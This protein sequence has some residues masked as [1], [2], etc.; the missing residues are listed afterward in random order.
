V[1]VKCAINVQ[2]EIINPE[3]ATAASGRAGAAAGPAG[4]SVAVGQAWTPGP[5]PDWCNLG[6]MLRVVLGINL[7]FLSI[8]GARAVN[9]RAWASEF[10]SL[11]VTVE[12]VLIA[13]LLIGCGLRRLG[14]HARFPGNGTLLIGLTVALP[15]V[16]T[17]LLQHTMHP[18]VSLSAFELLRNALFAALLAAFVIYW[19]RLR[20]RA[21]SPALVEARLQALQ[22]RIRPHFLF[23][24]LNAVLGMMRADPRRAEGA[25]E[26]LSD[27]F[28]VLMRDSRE[29]IPL[30]GEVALCKQYLAIESLRLGQRLRIEWNVDGRALET[31]VPNLLLQPLVEN[32]VHHGIEPRPEGGL[33]RI[34]ITRKGNEVELTV[35]NPWHNVT[36]TPGHDGNH[37]AIDNIRQRLALIHDLEAR[38]V[39][40]ARDGQYEV[41]LTLPLQT[42]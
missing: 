19:A 30:S 18:L 28:R 31:L 1:P 23:N 38:L 25:L 36:P 34:D 37:M 21:G 32:A 6:I 10:L 42:A 17:W 29:R 33:I 4:R 22:A 14:R 40:T 20:E 2:S 11:A 41:R 35:A 8:A 15:G 24:S 3:P 26:D 39:T 12:P 16:L 5:L 9:F 7:L 27:L 13:S